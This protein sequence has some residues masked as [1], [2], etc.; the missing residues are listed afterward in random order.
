MHDQAATEMELASVRSL[1]A[2]SDESDSLLGVDY[3]HRKTGEGG[4]IYLTRFGLPFLEQLEP[5][6]W[7][8]PDWFAE[9][10]TRLPGTSVI[11]RVPSKPIHGISINLVVRFSRVG[12]EVPVDTPTLCQYPHVEF[13]SPFEEFGL[14]MELRTRCRNSAG[15]RLMTKRPLAI[16]APAERMQLWRTGRLQS[17]LVA[18]VAQH[19]EIELDPLRQY[20]LLY[21]WI[22]G[23]N[24]AQAVRTLGLA[25]P[26]REEFLAHTTRRAIQDLEHCG[27]R[28]IDIK[29]EHIV[30]R[31]RPDGSLLRQ[32][33]GRLAYALVD[34]EL[35]ERI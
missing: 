32:R 27:F 1:H 19:P 7:Y 25:G 23:L 6:N 15:A 30:L 26:A 33:D 31:L 34:Y 16:W 22:D 35:L 10:R 14:V 5:E 29:P 13:N 9:Q 4:D 2:P 28:M 3:T 21:G 8:A 20:I 12:E 24:A 18:K 11:Y 17:K